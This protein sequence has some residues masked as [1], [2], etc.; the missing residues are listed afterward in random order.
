MEKEKIKKIIGWLD[1]RKKNWSNYKYE[2]GSDL[3]SD[4]I[5]DLETTQFILNKL[6]GDESNYK[7]Y[8][9]NPYILLYV[10]D[11]VNINI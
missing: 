10:K 3:Y 5:G 4:I 1:G 9:D 11:I 8:N 6:I 7:L 2:L